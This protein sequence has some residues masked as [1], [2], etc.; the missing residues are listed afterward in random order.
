MK[1]KRTQ[2]KNNDIELHYD[3]CLEFMEQIKNPVL[4]ECCQTIYRDFKEKPIN[5][6]ATTGSH[7]N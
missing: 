6:P 3:K 4:K 1:A 2:V 5:K 7:M